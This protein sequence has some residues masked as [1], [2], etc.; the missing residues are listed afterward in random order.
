MIFYFT[1]NL[2]LYYISRRGYFMIIILS[3]SH[4]LLRT[5]EI[6]KVNEHIPAIDINI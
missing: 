4:K 6:I 3:L 5:K 2:K 1:K